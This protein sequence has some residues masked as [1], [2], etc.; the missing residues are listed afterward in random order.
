MLALL[1]LLAGWLGLARQPGPHTW[2]VCPEGCDFISIQAAI[3]AAGPGDTVQVGPGTYKENLVIEKPLTL[4][5]AGP[6]QTSVVGPASDWITVSIEAERVTVEGFTISSQA[7]L[8]TA[9]MWPVGVFIWGDDVRIVGNRILDEE[10][11]IEIAD[12]TRD[13]EIV[14]NEIL[15]CFSGIE[16][17]SE[18]PVLITENTISECVNGIALGV[19]LGVPSDDSSAI[20]SR[21]TISRNEEAGIGATL[22]AIAE[23]SQN[24]IEEN[25]SWGLLGV[26]T[27]G[28]SSLTIYGN[29]IDGNGKEGIKLSGGVALLLQNTVTENG[30]DGI[31]LGVE[32]AQV[33][34]NRISSNG[35]NGISILSPSSEEAL[36]VIIGD[37]WWQ[38]IFTNVIEGND[39][40]GI[41]AED[42]SLILRCDGNELSGNKLG[43]FS[44]NLQGVC[45]KAE[46]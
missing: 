16:T 46:E 7:K 22:G 29:I 12:H 14:R 17:I 15:K 27:E 9:G 45:R 42:A 13:V 40:Y 43:D 30:A 10:F 39:G 38:R 36:G 4:K 21:N 26:S 35:G 8:S 2:T 11:C 34:G 41:F 31:I 33:A 25:G 18:N 23:I 28:S 24:V 6:E 20:I 44:E 32:F 3:D 37:R 1:A 19:M 5:G